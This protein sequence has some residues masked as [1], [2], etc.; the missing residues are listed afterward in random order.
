MRIYAPVAPGDEIERWRAMQG[1][2][3]GALLAHGRRPRAGARCRPPRL[4]LA[5]AGARRTSGSVLRALKDTLDP[6][7]V[8]NPGV[9][10]NQD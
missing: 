5:R 2:A 9:L 3:Y 1:A 10:I 4:A 8:L 7:G 6:L